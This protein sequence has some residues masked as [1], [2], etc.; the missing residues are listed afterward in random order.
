MMFYISTCQLYRILGDILR[1]LYS[2]RD[3]YRIM[4]EEQWLSKVSSIMRF[5][6]ELKD[7]LSKVPP[8]LQ[9]G[10]MEEVSDDILR[11]R[12]VLQVRYFD[13]IR[14]LTKECLMSAI[15]YTDQVWYYLEDKIMLEKVALI[16][17]L[18]LRVH[19]F[20]SHPPRILFVFCIAQRHDL[21]VPFGITYS[22]FHTSRLYWLRYLYS[23]DG[24]TWSALMSQERRAR[25]YRRR[26]GFS[27]Q[28]S[29]TDL[30]QVHLRR[31]MSE[32][33]GND[34]FTIEY[35]LSKS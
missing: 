23:C 20:A 32:S 18:P 14:R 31:T 17:Q 11:Q 5:D 16:C 22:V 33:F 2:P 3:D 1:E 27:T 28:L 8:F 15:C 26:L 4:N 35:Q 29:K 7:W 12:N 6:K 34:A 25:W 19:D 9:W 10:S 13:F 21:L 30:I 24:A